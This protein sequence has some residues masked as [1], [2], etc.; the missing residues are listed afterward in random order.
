MPDHLHAIVA[1][2]GCTSTLSAIVQAYK[3]IATLEIKRTVRCGRVFQRGFY[4]R[5]VRD[6]VELAAL[7]EYVV[8]NAIRACGE[9]RSQRTE[10]RASSAPT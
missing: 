4:D 1:L 3:S 9:S 2:R 5:I 7:R 10:G 6:E 8:H